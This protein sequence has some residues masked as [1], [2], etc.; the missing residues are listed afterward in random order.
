VFRLH[1]APDS[2]GWSI[3]SAEPPYDAK[4][5]RSSRLD[6]VEWLRLPDEGQ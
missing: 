6:E 3:E 2:R 4:T 1:C 5:L